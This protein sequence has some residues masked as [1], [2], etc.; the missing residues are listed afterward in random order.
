MGD[1]GGFLPFRQSYCWK[2]SSYPPN[3][4]FLKKFWK[5]VWPIERPKEITKFARKGINPPGEQK[6][7]M[8]FYCIRKFMVPATFPTGRGMFFLTV[9]LPFPLVDIPFYTWR[10]PPETANGISVRGNCSHPIPYEPRCGC[11]GRSGWC[12]DG[13]IAQRSF[14]L[15]FHLSLSPFF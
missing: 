1:F 5:S 8:I 2:A 7:S 14:G 10:L 13:L 11:S 4:T 12:N 15:M 9:L 3:T 6:N